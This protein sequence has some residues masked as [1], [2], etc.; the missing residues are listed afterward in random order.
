M[1]KDRISQVNEL[2]KQEL[3]V[4]VL[5]EAEAPEGALVTVTRV[6]CSP[7]LQQAKVY[8]SVMPDEHAKEVIKGLQ[9]NI[10]DIQQVLNDRLSMRPVPRIQWVI[11]EATATAQ[12]IESLLDQIK[13]A[14]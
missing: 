13:K 10:Y 7:N 1:A 4:I 12:R 8:V 3:G 6:D 2:L 5:R 14:E 11:E 9:R